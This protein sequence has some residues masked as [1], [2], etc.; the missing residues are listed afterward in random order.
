MHARSP[1]LK[2]FS[3]ER[4]FP[5]RAILSGIGGVYATDLYSPLHGLGGLMSDFLYPPSTSHALMDALNSQAWSFDGT[6][7]HINGTRLVLK[8]MQTPIDPWG[9]TQWRVWLEDTIHAQI[10]RFHIGSLW[11]QEPLAPASVID[12]LLEQMG[13]IAVRRLRAL[14]HLLAKNGFDG[15]IYLCSDEEDVIYDAQSIRHT[16]TATLHPFLQRTRLQ[17]PAPG[18]IWIPVRGLKLASFSSAHETL[19]YAAEIAW[20][21]HLIKI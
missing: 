8:Q 11:L 19:L 9:R 12:A 4:V 17:Q 18:G 7:T 3:Y 6:L 21:D 10:E 1:G 14:S 2:D 5:T 16:R 15:G 20:I 13:F